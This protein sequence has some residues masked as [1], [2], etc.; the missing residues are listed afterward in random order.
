MN[1]WMNEW[2]KRLESTTD[3]SFSPSLPPSPSPLLPPSSFLSSFSFP[4]YQLLHKCLVTWKRRRYTER[5]PCWLGAHRFG[6]LWDNLKLSSAHSST[7]PSRISILENAVGSSLHVVS[8]TCKK[9][10]EKCCCLRIQCGM[11]V[12]RT[13]ICS[14]SWHCRTDCHQFPDGEVG[15]WKP[16][17]E[18]KKSLLTM[19]AEDQGILVESGS[20]KSMLPPPTSQHARD[21][22]GTPIPKKGSRFSCY[23]YME[24][25]IYHPFHRPWENKKNSDCIKG[26]IL[27]LKTMADAKMIWVYFYV[28]AEIW[29]PRCLCL[30]SQ[31]HEHGAIPLWVD[32]SILVL[33]GLMPVCLLQGRTCMWGCRA[34]SWVSSGSSQAGQLEKPYFKADLEWCI[35]KP[36]LAAHR[37]PATSLSLQRFLVHQEKLG[38]KA[39]SLTS[40]RLMPGA[41]PAIAI[42]AGYSHQDC[43]SAVSSFPVR[44]QNPK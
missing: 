26:L 25:E 7:H 39:R 4:F 36:C 1:E 30:T 15:M 10:S 5:L 13:C 24:R 6:A 42:P 12:A 44:G 14:P 22:Q 33:H 16:P 29:H 11:W 32:T 2:T 37:L 41:V 38:L 3:L 28:M 18:E 43:M 19:D 17:P 20:S 21:E 9:D 8:R 31:G 34:A 23:S 40:I 27:I 35:L